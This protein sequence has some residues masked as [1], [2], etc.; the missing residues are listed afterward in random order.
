MYDKTTSEN[1]FASLA[2]DAGLSGYYANSGIDFVTVM[3]IAFGEAIAGVYLDAAGKY[4][5]WGD[6]DARRQL[7]DSLRAKR[8]RYYIESEQQ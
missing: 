8:L 2:V 6:K 4:I 3:R 5:A 7:C 1:L